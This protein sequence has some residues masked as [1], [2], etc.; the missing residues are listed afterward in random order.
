MSRVVN[1]EAVFE[2]LPGKVKPD[3][4]ISDP[5]GVSGTVSENPVLEFGPG[6]FV[7][8]ITGFWKTPNQNFPESLYGTAAQYPPFSIER[9]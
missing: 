5:L 3:I 8:H 6:A 2:A 7:Q 1:V 9:Y 4:E